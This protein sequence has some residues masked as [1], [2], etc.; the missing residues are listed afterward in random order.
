MKE[1][2]NK[3]PF[4]NI[5]T[6][7]EKDFEKRMLRV[8]QI[9]EETIKELKQTDNNFG[10]ICL[11]NNNDNEDTK[12]SWR[13][14]IIACETLLNTHNEYYSWFFSESYSDFVKR[15]LDYKTIIKFAYALNKK[16][17]EVKV[18]GF[19]LRSTIT[20]MM[21]SGLSHWGE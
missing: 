20:D 16:P 12:A 15:K 9:V 17:K 6:K 2:L 13:S 7:K 8:N 19:C 3:I 1:W 5:K 18:M 10:F 21:D 11:S 4:I 14:Y